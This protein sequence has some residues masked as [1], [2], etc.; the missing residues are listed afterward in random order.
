MLASSCCRQ[1]SEGLK[2]R[3]QTKTCRKPFCNQGAVNTGS[4]PPT[5]QLYVCHRPFRQHLFD[6][7]CYRCLPATW[8]GKNLS[9][10]RKKGAAG[11]QRNAKLQGLLGRQRFSSQQMQLIRLHSAWR[12]TGRIA[13]RIPDLVLHFDP[14]LIANLRSVPHLT[15]GKGSKSTKIKKYKISFLH[16]SRHVCMHG[17]TSRSYIISLLGP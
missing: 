2:Q 10:H 8:S 17:T 9:P 1:E 13:P 12:E 5:S 16:D 6:H 7:P 4:R 15:L 14:M 11:M 3:Q